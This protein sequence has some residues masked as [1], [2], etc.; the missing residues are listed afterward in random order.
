[1]TSATNFAERL[2]SQIQK[3]DDVKMTA[4]NAVVRGLVAALQ[5][6]GRVMRSDKDLA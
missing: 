2:R 5:L 1:V 3:P 6:L 4:F